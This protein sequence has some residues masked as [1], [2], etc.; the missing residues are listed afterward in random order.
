MSNNLIYRYQGGEILNQW[1]ERRPS[2]DHGG[3]DEQSVKEN[4]LHYRAEVDDFVSSYTVGNATAAQAFPSCKYAYIFTR[5][6]FQEFNEFLAGNL[7]RSKTRYKAL[8]K[9]V[10]IGIV[11]RHEFPYRLYNLRHGEQLVQVYICVATFIYIIVNALEMI[12]ERSNQQSQV[13]LL[14][15]VACLLEHHLQVCTHIIITCMQLSR[16]LDHIL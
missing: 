13:L 1:R 4:S 6:F 8:D 7:L 16:H 14:Y 10:V 2:W 15:D 11:C 12:K 5:T 9:T 3:G